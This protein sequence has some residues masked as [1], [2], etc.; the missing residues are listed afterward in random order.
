MK[1]IG[2]ILGSGLNKLSSV[3]E[4][5]IVLFK[6]FKGIHKKKILSGKLSG[7]EIIIFEGRNH[8]YEKVSDEK[9]LMN[10][11]KAKVYGIDLLIITNAAGG[12]NPNYKVADLM[13]ISSHINLLFKRIQYTDV[14]NF[15]DKKLFS[16]II[17]LARKNKLRLHSG[18]YCAG[19]GPSYETNKEIEFLKKINADAVGMSTIPE[20][21]Y[22]N[23]LGI[24]TIAISCIT[25]LLSP[26]SSVI[27]DHSEVLKA[28]KKA[29]E[30][31]LKLIN[32]IINDN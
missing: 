26:H 6:D 27:L 21:I 2:I 30:N 31:F 28:G 16:K 20:I 9:V 13:I 15:Y 19:S 3:L 7:R 14:Q 11:D 23:K 18:V 25:N 8:Y 32:L 22:A 10:V 5:K 24:K 29:H 4:D 12:L 17:S 1:K